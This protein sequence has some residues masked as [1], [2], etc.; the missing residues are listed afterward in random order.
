MD[1]YNFLLTELNSQQLKCL[2]LAKYQ[3]VKYVG[4]YSTNN[5]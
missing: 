4:Q 5:N 2:I 3:R 1:K